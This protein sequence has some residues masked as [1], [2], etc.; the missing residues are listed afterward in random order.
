MSGN[1][2]ASY[3]RGVVMGPKDLLT[4]ALS[5]TRS[6]ALVPV[7][8]DG[9]LDRV[10]DAEDR[11]NNALWRHL[12][13]AY[14]DRSALG[15]STPR[16]L[17]DRVDRNRGLTSQLGHFADSDER[18]LK[19][20]HNSSGQ[21]LRAA[22]FAPSIP[23]DH[24]SYYFVANTEEESGYLVSLLNAPCLQSAFQG[25]R[26]SDR[27]FMQH[28]WRRVPIPRFDAENVDHLEL[29]RLCAVAEEIALTLVTQVLSEDASQVMASKLIRRELKTAGVAD[30]IDAV[31]RR[32]M[33]DHS[34]SKYDRVNPHPWAV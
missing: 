7:K 25:A 13:E 26:R 17:W 4:F 3:V 33:P 21:I 19:V 11:V 15:I 18:L 6:L 30:E 16:T 23:A 14:R 10:N 8:E 20:A 2:P 28:I 32:V 9:S 1:V 22:R 31:V 27:H 12:D 24:S 34:I 5:Q 29:A